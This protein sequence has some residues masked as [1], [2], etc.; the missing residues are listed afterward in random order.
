MS[1]SI[2]LSPVLDAP[3]P[4]IQDNFYQ[5]VNHDWL[6]DPKN[7][8]PDEYPRWG[9]FIKLHDDGLKNQ[10]QLVKDLE[11][12]NDHNEEEEKVYAIWKAVTTL[13]DNFSNN[14]GNYNPIV[15][16]LNA[17]DAFMG[18]D[19]DGDLITLSECW[20][21]FKEFYEKSE[22]DMKFPKKKE[23]KTN[24]ENWIGVKCMQS[25]TIDGKNYKNFW[26]YYKIGDL[27]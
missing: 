13:F 3:K 8:I 12:Q 18:D 22:T 2:A 9:G 16:E 14:V 25:S 10:I 17:L 24:L 20:N 21:H 27:I 6:N 23:F 1:E 7:Q 19:N 4:R 11:N 15:K 5:H 26:K